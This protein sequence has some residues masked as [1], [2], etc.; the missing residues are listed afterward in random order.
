[1]K[2]K[3]GFICFLAF[4]IGWINLL[5]KRKLLCQHT[6]PRIVAHT[7]RLLLRKLININRFAIFVFIVCACLPST[8]AY[9]STFP[10]HMHHPALVFAQTYLHF[11]YYSIMLWKYKNKLIESVIECS[12]VHNRFIFGWNETKRNLIRNTIYKLASYCCFMDHVIVLLGEL[13][14]DL[15]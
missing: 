13:S 3:C 8:D 10:R 14:R 6:K 1:M 9:F 11:S 15:T 2:W 12:C 4:I 7:P 5:V